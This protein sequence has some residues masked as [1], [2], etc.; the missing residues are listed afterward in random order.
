MHVG[1]VQHRII[2]VPG[3]FYQN[4]SLR[5]KDFFTSSDYSLE[6][7]T[8]SNN[9]PPHESKRNN[10]PDSMELAELAGHHPAP[11]SSRTLSLE[12]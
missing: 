12:S 6:P 7:S 9:T 1:L 5:V 3:G 2:G 8:N 4:I 11:K 10:P